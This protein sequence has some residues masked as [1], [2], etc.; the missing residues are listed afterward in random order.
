M[1]Q[2]KVVLLDMLAVRA[3]GQI[4]RARALLGRIRTFDPDSKIIVLQADTADNFADYAQQGL[5]VVKVHFPL[6]KFTAQQRM[7][8]GNLF[9]SGVIRRRN[10]DTYISFAHYLPFRFPQDVQ[11]IVA[12]SNLAPFSRAA[13]QAEGVLIKARMLIQKKSILASTKRATNVLALSRACRDV[14]VENGI[15]SDKIDIIPNGVDPKVCV[16]RGRG[17]VLD[18]N[19]I[20][21]PFALYVSHFHRYKNHGTLIDAFAALPKRMRKR[22]QLVMVGGVFDKTYFRWVCDQIK[23]KK[24]SDSIVVIPGLSSDELSVLYSSTTL[25]VFPSL[26]ENCPNILLEAMCFGLPI[27]ASAYKPMPE[28]CEGAAVLFDPL[29][30]TDLAEKLERYLVDEKGRAALSES[31]KRRSENY[32][33]DR[34]AER[35]TA[36]YLGHG[37]RD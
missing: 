36:L 14:L 29:S 34:F 28:F 20:A 33:W 1:S 12:V 18:D 24:L 25:F 27:L 31:A 19:R 4:T 30:H 7:A 26:I 5:E 32:S 21:L 22:F 2:N 17:A 16:K 6:R 3:G 35:M 9:L 37:T 15:S 13:F 23:R 11:S 8:W 10:V